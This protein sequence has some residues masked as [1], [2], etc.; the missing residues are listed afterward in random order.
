M[1]NIAI[2]GSGMA[3]FGAAHQLHTEGIRP[4]IFEK[5]AYYG[6]HT[7]SFQFGNG[8]LFDVGPHI[9]FTKDKRIQGLFAESVD[10]QYESVQIYLNNY[11]K[12][13]WPQHPVQ[14]HL[15]GLPEDIIV[16][17]INDFVEEGKSTM[18]KGRLI[19]TLTGCYQASDD[20][21][22]KNFQCSIRES[23]T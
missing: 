7:A 12:G 6:G 23:T 11:W 8:F 9:S 22:P 3:G 14:L 17:V 5:N 13:Y 2:L 20:R 18:M 21:S 10:H 16:N 15:N 1:N 19:I 4:L